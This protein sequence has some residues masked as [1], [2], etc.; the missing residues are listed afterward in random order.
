MPLIQEILSEFREKFPNVCEEGKAQGY[1]NHICC[2]LPVK[3]LEVFLLSSLTRVR[4]ELN[5]CVCKEK[6]TFNVV[7]RKD[8]PCYIPFQEN[9]LKA[10]IDKIKRDTHI[11]R[12]KN[13]THEKEELWCCLDCYDDRKTNEALSLINL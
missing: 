13:I 3:A 5:D 10:K 8:K 4:E 11:M 1:S 6:W 2:E 12:G 9:E 7:H